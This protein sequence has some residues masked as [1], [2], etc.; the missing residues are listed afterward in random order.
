MIRAKVLLAGLWKERLGFPDSLEPHE[1]FKLRFPTW[2]PS[3]LET[4]TYNQ[5]VH[6]KNNTP[7]QKYT[8]S[9]FI[10]PDGK[11]MPSQGENIRNHI[12]VKS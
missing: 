10:S 8:L 2:L 5:P 7:F 9:S 6:R 3:L 12:L 4:G 1:K 11:I